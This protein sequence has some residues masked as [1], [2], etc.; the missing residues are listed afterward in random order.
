MNYQQDRLA[1]Q[2]W[3]T[4]LLTREDWV[5]LDTETTGL[6]RAQACQVAITDANGEALL[7]NL[8]KPTKPIERRAIDI[9]HITNEMIADAPEFPELYPLILEAIG[10]REVIIYN[11]R[12]DTQ[13]IN[14]NCRA[15]KLPDIFT[16]SRRVTCAMLWYSQYEGQWNEYHGNYRWQRLPEGDHSALGDC[17]ATLEVIR[18]MAQH[19]PTLR[20]VQSDPLPRPA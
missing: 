14:N 20:P 5:I 6:R 12:F 16:K 11:S 1:A 19:E 8:V 9:H 7:D 13:V 2:Q 18:R 10:D 17:R 15:H 4:D 3:A